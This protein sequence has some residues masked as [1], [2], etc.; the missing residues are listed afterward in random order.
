MSTSQANSTGFRGSN[1]GYKLKKPTG[2]N[3]PPHSSNG[4]DEYGFSVIPGGIFHPQEEPIPFMELGYSA[5]FW[6]STKAMSTTYLIPWVRHISL[7]SSPDKI[8][9]SKSWEEVGRSVRCVK[10]TY[11]IISTNTVNTIT[12]T[13]CVSGGSI[14]S[15]GGATIT[16]RGVCWS[17][18]PNPTISDNYTVDGEG[19]GSFASYLTELLGS[20]QY[21]I[22]AYAT[23]IVGTSY[24][25]EVIFTTSDPIIPDINTEAIHNVSETTANCGGNVTSNGGSNI[26]IRGVCWGIN[27]NPTL[28]DNFTSD[29]TGTGAFT[30]ILTG[31][32]ELTQYYV[33]AYATNDAGTAYGDE[34]TFTT[35]LPTLITAEASLIDTSTVQTGGN[36]TSSGGSSIISKGVCWSTNQ[37]PTL[38]DNFT[39]DGTGT[40]NFISNL[41][42]LNELTQYYASAYATNEAGTTYGNE[43]S[44]TTISLPV[45]STNTGSVITSTSALTGG[46]ITFNGGSE[47]T[48]RGVCWSLTQNPTL[49]DNFT[50]DGSGNGYFISNL[51]GLLG[52]TQYYIRA[53]ATNTAGSVYGNEISIITQPPITATLS[54]VITSEITQS[55]AISGGRIISN[56]GSLV[57]AR[58]VCWST[59]Q[60]PTLVDNFTSDSSGIGDFISNITGI[61][62]NN[63]YYVKAYATNSVGTSYGNEMTFKFFIQCGDVLIDARDGQEYGTVLIDNQCWISENL[64]ASVYN[65]GT[66]IQT[67]TSSSAW[68]ALD[69]GGKCW[70]NNDSISY[71]GTYGVLYNGFAATNSNLCPNGWH[72]PAYTELQALCDYLGGG[73]GGPGNAGTKL[74]EAGTTHWIQDTGATNESG[75]TGLP[76]G[77]RKVSGGFD[78]KG[79]AGPIFSSTIEG[80]YLNSLK[81]MSLSIWNPAGVVGWGAGE[82]NG[83]S[84]RCVKD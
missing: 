60:N 38:A 74:K 14:S 56:G 13:S 78:D 25:N 7:A 54:T 72:V 24:G 17:I 36:I 33:R 15:S 26:N 18:N 35:S 61:S 71:H 44:F 77:Y 45:L 21:Y 31:L 28:T 11:G 41:T 76:S 6:T 4:S 50:T 73:L 81:G 23:N 20:T 51:T 82:N 30:S 84:I 29:G 43:I 59:N 10:S 49:T 48:E 19:I 37:N 34:I 40:G 22:R 1:E 42:G 8:Y 9:R 12:P 46:D 3:I 66:A 58:G 79:E 2:W 52:S 83:A 39:N 70:Y 68:A 64:K 65:N 57:T 53:Y 5:W 27:Q 80:Y 69:D 32:T 47:I 75:F 62:I 55:T 67:V 63:Q 16:S